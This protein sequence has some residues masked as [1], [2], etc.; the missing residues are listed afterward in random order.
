CSWRSGWRSKPRWAKPPSRPAPTGGHRRS[1]LLARSGD[2][3]AFGSHACLLACY[4][5]GSGRRGPACTILPETLLQVIDEETAGGLRVEVGA[6]LGEPAHRHRGLAN[7]LPFQGREEEGGHPSPFRQP[8]PGLARLVGEPEPP[9]GPRR[10]ASPRPLED[11][12]QELSVE[13]HH[14]QI[15]RRLGAGPE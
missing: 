4:R 1:G 2:A 11:G 13:S 5:G 15:P 14:R 7:R 8:A 12:V 10:L 3:R 6:L 9:L